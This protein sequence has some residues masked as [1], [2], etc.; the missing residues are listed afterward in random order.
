MKYILP[1]VLLASLPA[2][3]AAQEQAANVSVTYTW[4]RDAES[5]ATFPSGVTAAASHRVVGWL[6]AVGECAVSRESKDFSISGGGLYDYRYE[7][8]QAGPRA[9]RTFGRARPFV[10]LLAGVTRWRIRERLLD[11][12]GWQSVTDVSVQPGVGLDV[13]VTRHAA[14]RLGADLRV[15]FKHD[16]RFDTHYRA[17]LYRLHAGVAFHF[18]T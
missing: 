14:L 4:L 17:N 9:A 2:L 16:N 8:I 18:G 5:D 3:A 6:A 1:I 10:E 13:F 12:T 7:S 15:L 11:R